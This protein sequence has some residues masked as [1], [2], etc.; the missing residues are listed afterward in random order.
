MERD[1]QILIPRLMAHQWLKR[2]DELV[3]RAITDPVF[4]EALDAR[5]AD[6]GLEWVD[7]PYADHVALRL[8][9]DMEQPVLGGDSQWLSSN[10]GMPRD[11]IALLVILWAL[12]VLP[13][14]QRQIERQQS[15]DSTSQ[16]EM[17]AQEKPVPSSAEVGISVPYAALVA[18]FADRLGG[19]TRIDFALGQLSRHGFIDRRKNGEIA[20]GP[21]LDLA[22]DYNRMAD[23]VLDGALTDLLGKH[24]GDVIS[25]RE[26]PNDDLL[27]P[28]EDE[29]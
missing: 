14:R 26:N 19:K 11:A 24:L 7:H 21:L 25:A 17:F 15:V 10:L 4:R 28:E 3:R 1:L 23:R 9:R 22:L 16:G 20:E 8:K 29:A 5:L 12:L 2:D 27:P 6:C 13:K 18:D